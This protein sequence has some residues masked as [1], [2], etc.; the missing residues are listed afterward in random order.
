MSAA[1]R[2]FDDDRI[3][4]AAV[5]AE[6]CF[7]HDFKCAPAG[8]HGDQSDV[9]ISD[10]FGKGQG[11]PRSGND[12]VHT[13]RHCGTDNFLIIGK[14]DHDIDAERL[15]AFREL[16]CFADF[17]RKILVALLHESDLAAFDIADSDTGNRSVSAVSDDRRCQFGHSDAYAHSRL[18][19]GISAFKISYFQ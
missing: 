13:F 10:V 8:D 6:P 4:L 15:P 17:E 2:A 18:N 16:S 19:H 7:H 5:F 11:E 1:F 9:G 3:R 12:V 14:G